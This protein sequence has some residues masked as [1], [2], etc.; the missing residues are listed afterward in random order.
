VAPLDES[1]TAELQKLLDEE[2]LDLY[3]KAIRQRNHGLGIAAVAYLRRVVEN[4]IN[5][6]WDVLAA[7]AK[8]HDFAA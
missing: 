8:E 7:A 1:V 4:R 5:N 2:A 6:I 3:K